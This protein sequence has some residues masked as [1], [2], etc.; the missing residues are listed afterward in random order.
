MIITNN[1]SN[2][3]IQVSLIKQN[4]LKGYHLIL[5]QIIIPILNHIETLFIQGNKA[6]IIIKRRSLHLR[7]KEII[8]SMIRKVIRYILKLTGNKVSIQRFSIRI[9]FLLR[10]KRE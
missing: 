7:K 10:S 4:K 6:N 8:V 9:N 2:N 5:I 3:R 1:N